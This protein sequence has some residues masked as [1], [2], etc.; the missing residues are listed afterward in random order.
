MPQI[1]HNQVGFCLKVPL[2]ALGPMSAPRSICFHGRMEN[3]A[4]ISVIVGAG[5][6]IL[7]SAALP[8]IILLML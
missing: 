3:E 1:L 7:L 2:L 8:I 4:S 5:A 6:L